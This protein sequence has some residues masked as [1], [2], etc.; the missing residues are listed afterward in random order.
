MGGKLPQSLM[1][2]FLSG[3]GHPII[4]IDHLAFVIAVG[5]SAGLAGWLLALSLAFVVGT[6]AGCLLHLGGVTLPVAELVIAASVALLG[7]VIAFNRSLRPRVLAVLFHGV[8]IFHGW[9]Y[10]ESIVGAEQTPLVAYLAG[11]MLV[12]LV[13]AVLAGTM[14][15]WL[16]AADSS[17]RTGVRLAG[18]VVAGVG[19]ATFVGKIEGFLLPGLQ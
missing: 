8:G 12:Q 15:R 2:G 17:A 7:A 5:L 11:F 6:L 3:V 4:G 14:G 13:A 19:L 10:G 1:Q 16:M 18:A 9:A